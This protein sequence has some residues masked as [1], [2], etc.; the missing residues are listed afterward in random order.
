M[1]ATSKVLCGSGGWVGARSQFKIPLRRTSPRLSA[2]LF[3][4]VALAQSRRV[5]PAMLP[6]SSMWKAIRSFPKRRPFAT[7]I[8]LSLIVSGA[9]D[10][11]AQRAEGNNKLDVRRMI[12]FSS[13]GLFMGVLHWHLYMTLYAR[14][15]PGGATF[16]NLSM[17]QKLSDKSG[18]CDVIKQVVADLAVWMPFFYFPIFYSFKTVQNNPEIDFA[19]VPSSAM[20]MY[21]E[22]WFQD[23]TASLGVWIPGDIVSFTVPVWLRM[24]VC[25]SISF[26]WQALLSMTRGADV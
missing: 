9:S 12:T 19:A 3:S 17:R 25:L 11:V 15:F 7:N 24:P 16:A 4:N 6:T 26:A 23:N 20:Q 2:R 1:L 18:Q 10:V 22:T 13:F 14:L 5:T 21:R 8:G